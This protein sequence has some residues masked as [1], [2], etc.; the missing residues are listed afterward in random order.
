MN[1]GKIKV[2]LSLLLSINHNLKE[3]SLILLDIFFIV[4]YST[5]AFFHTTYYDHC[6]FNI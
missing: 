3:T 4:I 1:K 6:F 5:N 2:I